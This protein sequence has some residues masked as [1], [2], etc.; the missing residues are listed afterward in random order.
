[1]FDPLPFIPQISRLPCQPEEGAGSSLDL[2]P[3][4]LPMGNGGHSVAE[5][6]SADSL[7]LIPLR[8]WG[9]REKSEAPSL[10]PPL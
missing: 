7:S 6:H 5:L 2:A 1:G 8:L 9:E 4:L 10:S 3:F